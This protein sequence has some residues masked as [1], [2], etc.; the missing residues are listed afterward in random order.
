LELTGR[1][2]EISAEDSPE[3]SPSDDVAILVFLEAKALGSLLFVCRED[4]PQALHARYREV[5]R[6]VPDMDLVAL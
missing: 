3:Q 5:Q 2:G 1:S 4:V 6:R